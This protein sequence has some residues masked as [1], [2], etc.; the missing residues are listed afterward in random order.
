[1]KHLWLILFVINSLWGQSFLSKIFPYKDHTLVFSENEKK[2]EL[3]V[4]NFVIIG[5]KDSSVLAGKYTG[6]SVTK[7]KI[8]IAA[9]LSSPLSLDEIQYVKVGTRPKYLKSIV[10]GAFSGYALSYILMD[11][12]DTR[13]EKAQASSGGQQVWLFPNS[14]WRWIL[15]VPMGI[16][17]G[18]FYADNFTVIYSDKIELR[19]PIFNDDGLY[20]SISNGK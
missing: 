10:A 13:R 12:Y 14:F 8:R 6:F 18:L 7:K 2:Y 1:M 20:I 16:G 4:G 17:G 3:P 11:D 19:S 5:L 9:F 15:Y